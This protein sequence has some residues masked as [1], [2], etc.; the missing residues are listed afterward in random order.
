MPTAGGGGGH[1]GGFSGGGFSGGGHGGGFHGGRGFRG[2]SFFFFG[3]RFGLFGLLSGPIFA[4][5][6][7]L[8]MMVVL[9]GMLVSSIGNK[10]IAYSSDVAFDY[11]MERYNE[12]FKKDSVGYEDKILLVFFTNDGYTEYDYYSMNGDH[13]TNAAYSLMRD[14]RSSALTYALERN[15]SRTGYKDTLGRNL[16]CFVDDMAVE[17]SGISNP[18]TCEEDPHV[19]GSS[20]LVNRSEL[21]IS[22]ELVNDS[23][24]A[25]T[26]QTGIQFVIVVDDA[27]A[28]FGY[29]RPTGLI[30]ALIFL[31]V[32][33]TVVIVSMV[34]IVKN[35]KKSKQNKNG[36]GN[37]SGGYTTGA[38]MDADQKNNDFPNGDN[39]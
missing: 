29:E 28:V 36:P 2:G 3:P 4:L 22:A 20:Q 38:Q 11:A 31:L 10:K 17:F 16:S 8:I 15:I 7:V 24:K 27:A 35:W 21:A 12:E 19:N 1:G 34:G 13:L 9:G 33:A 14:D 30:F 18:F 26:E 37:P 25:F 6:M 39:W 5:A 23:L 32:F